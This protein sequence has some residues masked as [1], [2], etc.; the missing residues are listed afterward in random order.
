MKATHRGYTIEV[1]R[2]RSL[3]ATWLLYTTVVRDSDGYMAVDTFED[4]AETVRD[5]VKYMRTRIDNE[6]ADPDPWGENDRSIP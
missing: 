2:Q 1:K 6:L 3:G 5:M 4:S